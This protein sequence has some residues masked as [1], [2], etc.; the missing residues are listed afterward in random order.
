[1]TTDLMLMLGSVALSAAAQLLLKLNATAPAA[2][3]AMAGGVSMG[4]VTG[5]IT[6]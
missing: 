4:S 6:P 1:M 5:I 3:A 2:R